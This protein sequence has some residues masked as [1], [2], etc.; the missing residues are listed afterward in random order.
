MKLSDTLTGEK[1]EFIPASD[2]VKIY[3]CGV[4]PYSA[5]H[6]G[7]AMSYIV[8]D[9]LHRYLEFSGYR[10][11]RVQNFTDIDD[12]LITRAEQQGTTVEALAQ[13]FID[14]YFEDMRA[15]NV[16]EADEY[17]RAT[18]EVPKIIEVIAGL[19]DKDFAY[20]SNGDVY[21]RV[22]KN[23]SYGKLSHRTV[24]SMRAG[25]RVEPGVE[26]EHLMDFALWKSAKLGEP[27]WESPWGPG[28]PGWHIEC[29]AM[30]LRYLGETIDIHGGGQDL[31][32]PHHENEIAQSE[33][34]TGV[35][36]FARFWMHNGLLLKGDEKMSKSLGNLVSIREALEHYS[37]DAIRV[38]V[39]KSHYRGPGY[40]SDD[41]L[42]ENERALNRMRQALVA[43]ANVGASDRLA[44]TDYRER[45]ITAMDDDLN[46][47][48]A[49]A[50]LFDLARDINRDAEAGQDVAEAQAL[51]REFG[52]T[53]FGL[54]IEE[55]QTLVSDDNAA[56]IDALVARRTELRA[57]KQFGDADAMRD[58]LAAMGVTLT[59]GADGTSWHLD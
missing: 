29:S 43:P 42:A 8:F 1:R 14:E 12:K 9:V 41:A 48:Q 28:R 16:R 54:T 17:P 13:Q 19:I 6:V 50:T 39:L 44:A 37:A 59:D 40:Y 4:T 53:V 15:L 55:H 51:L 38:S 34:F 24:D 7:H 18:R 49:L 11:H 27:A 45:F 30:S 35:A 46:T 21:F 52:G 5:S 2:V 10:V 47:P 33:A 3:V 20:P 22:T 57:A 31:V 32:F 36:P 56:R 23:P 26:K 25:A 58:E